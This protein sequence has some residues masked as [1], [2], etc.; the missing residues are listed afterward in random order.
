MLETDNMPD[1]LLENER[2]IVIRLDGN[3]ELNQ[4]LLIHG[5]TVGTVFIMNYSPKYAGLVNL[6]VGG[7]MI[8]LRTG[9][10][11]TMDWTRI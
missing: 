7:K 8:S 10:F 5:I 9:D 3:T 2:A 4:F 6:T 11:K 1:I